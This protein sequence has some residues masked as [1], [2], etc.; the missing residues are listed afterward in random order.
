MTL[1][2]NLENK[3]ITEQA[4]SLFLDQS[5]SYRHFYRFLPLGHFFT[6]QFISDLGVIT[7]FKIG[8][9]LDLE[10]G[11]NLILKQLMSW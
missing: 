8:T 3:A 9:N 4:A 7:Y 2:H 6:V 1:D 11:L 5:Y 10:N